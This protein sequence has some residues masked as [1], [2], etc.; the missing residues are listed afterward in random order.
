MKKLFLLIAFMVASSLA[1]S[2]QAPASSRLLP[3][4]ALLD[5]EANPTSSERLSLESNWILAVLDA[6]LPSARIFLS[7]L[8]EKPL[9]FNSQ[10]TV[11]LIG[12]DRT[13]KD[14]SSIQEKLPGIRWVYSKE[15]NVI[16]N[17]NLP[18][19]PAMIGLTKNQKIAWQFSGSQTSPEKLNS[20][21]Q[22]WVRT[23]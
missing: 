13:I 7:T 1:A 3:N 8:A 6:S 4:V 17:L 11:L 5:H 2:Q 14:L 21:I 16:K 22:G 9:T 10:I 20:M 19:T 23:Q 12:D 18:G 15:L